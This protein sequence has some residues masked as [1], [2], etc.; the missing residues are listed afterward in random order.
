MFIMQKET[1]QKIWNSQKQKMEI[2]IKLFAA[3]WGKILCE[4]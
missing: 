4:M 3:F 2:S 1:P